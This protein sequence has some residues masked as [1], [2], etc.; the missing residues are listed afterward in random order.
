M[1]NFG[2]WPK[3]REKPSYKNPSCQIV[4]EMKSKRIAKAPST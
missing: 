3:N 4:K 1:A 2:D